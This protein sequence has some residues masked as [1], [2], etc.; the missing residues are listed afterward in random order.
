M[1]SKKIF[2]EALD[3]ASLILLLEK[4][5]RTNP[6]DWAVQIGHREVGEVNGME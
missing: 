3:V 4:C 6:R 5:R 1:H 2:R